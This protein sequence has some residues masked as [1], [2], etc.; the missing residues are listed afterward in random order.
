MN[1]ERSAG[2]RSLA[3]QI[4]DTPIRGNTMLKKLTAALVAAV[5]FAVPVMLA[6]A[7]A[8]ARVA[9][10]ATD[11]VQATKAKKKK[12]VKRKK[13]KRKKAKKKKV[14]KRKKAKRKKAKKM[15]KAKVKKAKAA[16]KKKA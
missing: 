8:E 7:P 9:Q 4:R 2:G 16:P 11:N 10:V 15:K 5:F 13:A 3:G 14:V 1:G 6:N 12:V